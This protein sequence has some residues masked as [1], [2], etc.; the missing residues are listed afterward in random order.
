MFGPTFVDLLAGGEWTE[1]QNS[2]GPLVFAIS[3]WLLW[4]RGVAALDM[5]YSAAPVL[6]WI[7][8]VIA[9]AL[10]VPG[11]ALHLAYVEVGAFIWAVAGS[12][13]LIGGTG[14]FSRV[15]FPIV[16]ML[17]MIPLPNFLVGGVSGVLKQAVSLA[18]VDLLACLDYPVA[19]SGVIMTIGPYQ[20]LVAD[21]CAGVSNLFMLETLGILYLNL[22][23]TRSLLRNIVLP[24]LI[25]PI[26]FIANVARVAALALITYYM[27]DEAGQGFLHG[28]AGIVLFLL[29]LS[30]MIATDSVLRFFGRKS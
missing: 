12:A 7:C 9:S 20:L 4:K 14:L 1:A 30:L 3:L 28:F 10:Y 16:F 8:L 6:A 15:A 29:G 21:A 13:L 11:R 26:S 19:R 24:I 18:A 22:V 25:V 5:E 27:G 23:R 2:H 17:F